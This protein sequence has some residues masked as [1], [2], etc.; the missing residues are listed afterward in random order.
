MFLA[1]PLSTA[2]AVRGNNSPGPL[3]SIIMVDPAAAGV[4][5]PI[6]GTADRGGKFVGTFTVQQFAVVDN[7]IVAVGTLTGTISN[8]IGNVIGTVLKTVQLLVTI[9]K[10]TCEILLL[11]L[12]PIDLDL[13]GLQVHL[14][15]VVLEITADPTGGLLGSLLCAVANL[16]NSGG[17]LSDIANLLNQIL[18]LL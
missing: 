8:A 9:K 3:P 16:L 7:K 15:R 5:V 1:M 12:G 4:S 10:S 13:L 2:A 14:D 11:E 17:L 6:T 18:A